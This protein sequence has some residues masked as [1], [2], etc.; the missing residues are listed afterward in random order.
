MRNLPEL[1]SAINRIPA[2]AWARPPNGTAD[3]LNQRC[4]DHPSLSS[5]QVLGWKSNLP[6]LFC[7]YY[8]SELRNHDHRGQGPEITR[9]A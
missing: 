9:C 3:F 2:L 4:R 8:Y 7:I 1:R 6:I 5:E